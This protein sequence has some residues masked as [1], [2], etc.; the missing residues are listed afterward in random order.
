MSY[1]GNL[2]RIFWHDRLPSYNELESICNM[3]DIFFKCVRIYIAWVQFNKQ[4]NTS[5][6]SLSHFCYY[7]SCL[8]CFNAKM[9]TSFYMNTDSVTAFSET[10]GTTC[11]LYV[12]WIIKRVSSI[13]DI[14]CTKYNIKKYVLMFSLVFQ[15]SINGTCGIYIKKVFKSISFLSIKK[16]SIWYFLSSGVALL[17]YHNC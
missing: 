7:H 15:S 11:I 1:S 6:I 17:F 3:Y 9:Y 8:E 16:W 2:Q 12:T 10:A 14:S 13:N 5:L 4:S